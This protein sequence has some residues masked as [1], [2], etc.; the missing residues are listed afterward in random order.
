MQEEKNP[1]QKPASHVPLDHQLPAP[2][3][4]AS[5]RKRHRW[6]WIVILLLCALF[7][8]VI[9]RHSD[10]GQAKAPGSGRGGRRF[11]M[12]GPVPVT[13]AT[14]KSGS[15]GVYQS[16]IGTVTPVFT[17]SITAQ[18]T[19]VITAVH[20]REGQRV[21]KGD[22]LIDIDSRQYDAQLEEA[23]GALQRDQ[24]LLAEA[25]MDLDRYKTAWAHNAIPRQ[26]YEDQ[27]KLV[28]QTQGTVKNDEGTVH[29]DEV[30]VGYCHITSPITGRVGLRLVDPGNLVTAN[31]G[32][33]LVVVT[34]EQP[35]TVVFT[36]AEDGLNQVLDQ[37][38][39]GKALTVEAWDR[40]QS[41]KIEDGRLITIDNQIDTTT[42][43]VRLRAQF[44]NRTGELFPNQFVNTRLLVQTLQNQTLIPS[45]AVQHNGDEAFVY[46]IQNGAVKMQPVKTG[47]T[48]GGNSVVEGIKPGDVVADSSFEKLQSGSKITISKVVIPSTSP[49]SNAP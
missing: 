37:M 8:Y 41:K 29:Y 12:S 7:A 15:I 4:T 10:Q 20:Y 34:Q 6:V 24:N 17:D 43:T 28:L 2:G 18:V 11:G 19:G 36:L 48:D 49:E 5:P 47:V 21:R 3:A 1:E 13:T 26:Q 14:A 22:P 44:D 31:G 45:S 30:Q 39:H 35:I 46:L 9:L 33:T 40:S 42:G 23:Q 38:H 27:E 16:A 32:T 25:E